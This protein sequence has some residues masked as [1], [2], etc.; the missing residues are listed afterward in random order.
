VFYT[1]IAAAWVL[2]FAAHLEF[3]RARLA[4][5]APFAPEFWRAMC[6]KQPSFPAIAAMWSLMT[7]GMMA[8]A[9]APMLRTYDDL[10]HA[11]AGTRTGFW[12]LLAG[13]LAVWLGFSLLGASAQLG[14]QHAGLLAPDGSSTSHVLSAALLAFAGLYQFSALKHACLR[15]CRAPLTSFLGDWRAGW[16]YAFRKGVTE[17]VFCLGCCWA[18]MALAFAAGVMNLLF[19]GLA[20]ALMIA[21]KTALLGP[22]GSRALGAA[23]CL[24]SAFVLA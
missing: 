22:R 15:A 10:L 16:G 13:Y 20:M 21:E 3:T 17:G 24:A 19:M 18:L 23:L 5:D 14:L 2:L 1:L 12:F 11:G 8:P 6:A 9:A 4:F 7:I